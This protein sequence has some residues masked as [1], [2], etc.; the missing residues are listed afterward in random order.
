MLIT[1]KMCL[2]GILSIGFVDNCWTHST[3][4]TSVKSSSSIFTHQDHISNV[5]DLLIN[6]T[7]RACF[8]TNIV[9]NQQSW[10]N[11]KLFPHI[12][13]QKVR[14][15]IS[16]RANSKYTLE[17][18][19]CHNIWQVKI[20]EGQH[21]KHSYSRNM[22]DINH[23]LCKLLD[24]KYRSRIWKKEKSW[25]PNLSL[26]PPGPGPVTFLD[27]G[28]PWLHVCCNWP[29]Y[30]ESMGFKMF[31]DVWEVGQLMLAESSWECPLFLLPIACT[32]WALQ[33]SWGSAGWPGAGLQITSPICPELY[34]R[35]W[36]VEVVH[37]TWTGPTNMLN[38]WQLN[39]LDM[40]SL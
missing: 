34:T 12:W 13:Q 10:D 25:N 19:S 26:A 32:L 17:M 35:T 37:L 18:S 5:T 39:W 33:A 21:F 7:Y 28:R 31:W 38:H 4:I 1:D 27:S 20:C 11:L 3:R 14:Q 30:K 24:Y 6:I 2:Y 9:L 40:H 36:N 8:D 16:M 15:D 29:Y 23:P 22:S